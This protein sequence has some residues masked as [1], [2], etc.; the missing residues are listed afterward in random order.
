M[1]ISRVLVGSFLV[2]ISAAAQVVTVPQK[3]QIGSSNPATAEPPVTRPNTKPCIV[4]LFKDLKFADY[5][6]KT[7]DYTP[8]ADCPGPWQTVVFTADFIV[9]EGTQY[10]RTGAFYIGHVNVY[11]G[12]TAEPGSNFSPKWHVERDVT[13]LTAIF[14]SAQTGQAILGN[15]VGVYNGVNYNGIIYANAALEFYPVAASGSAPETPAVVVPVPDADGGAVT[16]NT[17]LDQLSQTVTLPTN[18]D[19]LYFDVITQSQINDEFWYLCAPNDVA[20]ELLTC[21]NTAFREAEI[22][23]DGTPAG[24]APVYPWIYTGGIDPYL[25]Q[26]VTGV[27]TLD[28][29]PYR[30]DLTPFA[31]LLSDGHQHTVALSVVNADSYFLATGNLLVYTDPRSTK[32]TGAV[33]YNNLAPMPSPSVDEDLSTDSAGNVSGTVTV[34]SDHKYSIVGYIMTSHGRIDTTVEQD[35]YFSNRQTYYVGVT[36]IPY[37]QDVAQDTKTQLLTIRKDPAITRK[38]IANFVYPLDISYTIG[39]NSNGTFFIDTTI[40][41]ENANRQYQWLNG[42]SVFTS[43]TDEDVNTVDTLNYDTSGNF[44]NNSG[45]RSSN[46]YLFNDSFGQCYSRS[47]AAANNVLTAVTDGRQCGSENK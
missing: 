28:F 42:A 17:E 43:E 30:V 3:P 32:V 13:D 20:G 46:R 11:Y 8:P 5:N 7:F 12:T 26:P 35:T 16:L 45:Q 6:P 25:W 41:Q 31:G 1:S 38:T 24:V 40:H 10:D 39:Q 9:T 27:Q 44:T 21:G 4:Q 33:T 22:T 36:E 23:V 19:R 18:V 15:F 37:V 47:I 2:V 14:E 34:K 29:M